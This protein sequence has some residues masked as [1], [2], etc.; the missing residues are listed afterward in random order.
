MGKDRHP[1]HKREEKARSRE[2]KR[3]PKEVK[4]TNWEKW[5]ERWNRWQRRKI[6]TNTR[7]QGRREA[8]HSEGVPTPETPLSAQNLGSG[9]QRR[10]LQG[11]PVIMVRKFTSN[12]SRIIHVLKL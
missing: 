3:I 1:N 9:L 6:H 7:R 8:V 10:F 2:A 12:L 5:Q 11:L 4:Q